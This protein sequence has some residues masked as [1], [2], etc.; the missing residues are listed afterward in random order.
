[1]WELAVIG[2]VVILLILIFVVAVGWISSSNCCRKNRRHLELLELRVET[3][4][5]TLQAAQTV[6]CAKAFLTSVGGAAVDRLSGLAKIITW[7]SQTVNELPAAGWTPVI[8]TVDG[9]LIGWTVPIGGTYF[10]EYETLI[11]TIVSA[12]VLIV[13]GQLLLRSMSAS[14]QLLAPNSQMVTGQLRKGFLVNL[15]Q[16]DIVSLVVLDLNGPGITPPVATGAPGRY[17][18]TL[19]LDLRDAASQSVDQA[20][21][22]TTAPGLQESSNS[23]PSKTSFSDPGSAQNVEQWLASACV[24]QAISDGATCSAAAVTM[25]DQLACIDSVFSLLSICNP[26]P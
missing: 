20:P 19:T 23:I 4:F 14:T 22:S 5:A 6:C 12:A 26:T 8:S 17:L 15:T 13:N 21:D 9:S 10:V 3:G 16:G 1:M 7:D 2:V 24:Q 18:H 11:S 25:T